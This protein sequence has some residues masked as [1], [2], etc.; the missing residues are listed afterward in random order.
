METIFG[1]RTYRAI[2]SLSMKLALRAAEVF[3]GHLTMT[4][5]CFPVGL[6]EIWSQGVDFIMT[7]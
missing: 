7:S 2:A 4:Q 1:R 6:L 5:H 3:Y